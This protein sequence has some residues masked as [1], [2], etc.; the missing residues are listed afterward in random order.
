MNCFWCSISHGQ[1]FY[2]ART[3]VNNYQDIALVLNITPTM[4]SHYQTSASGHFKVS[5]P[6]L[7]L[8][9]WQ[10]LRL[11][12][13]F[14]PSWVIPGHHAFI[15]TDATVAF[16]PGCVSCAFCQNQLSQF[17]WN[18]RS[19]ASI[20]IPSCMVSASLCCSNTFSAS[21]Q[22]PIAAFDSFHYILKESVCSKFGFNFCLGHQINLS[23]VDVHRRH[24]ALAFS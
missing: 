10:F 24:L 15:L 17:G 11:L 1:S 21:E 5:F 16:F 20:L 6:R 9:I 23:E 22:F 2:P 8:F 14:W 7:G 13:K 18:E 3:R 4:W 12:T 19:N